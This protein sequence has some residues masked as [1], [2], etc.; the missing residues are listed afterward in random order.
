[1]FWLFPSKWNTRPFGRLDRNRPDKIYNTKFKTVIFLLWHKKVKCDLM[2]GRICKNFGP[3]VSADTVDA[4]YHTVFLYDW[5]FTFISSFIF[6]SKEKV[7]KSFWKQL[8]IRLE[9]LWYRTLQWFSDW[10]FA[11]Q[12]LS[13][14]VLGCKYFWQNKT[15]NRRTL[16]ESK[17][18]S[19]LTMIVMKK[20]WMTGRCL[21][22]IMKNSVSCIELLAC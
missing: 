15:R 9:N 19:N 11:R 13:L 2:K 6:P 3:I 20:K 18:F 8:P 12:I 21:W 14:Y 5:P 10:F 7:I 22:S 1:M 16:S 4:E 17:M